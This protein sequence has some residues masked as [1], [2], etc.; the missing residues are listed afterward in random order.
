MAKENEF[1]THLV[2]LLEP[3][4]PVQAKAMFG[5]FGI[6]LKGLMFGLVADDTFY[7]KV[8]EKNRPDYEEKGLGPFTYQRGGKKFAMS[9]YRAPGEAID[10]AHDL[11]A[12]AKKAYDA[13]IRVA[14]HKKRKKP[15]KK[16]SR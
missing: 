14:G 6:Y 5:G 11:C 15:G 8:D 10:D 12:W 16:S 3:L 1:V 4:G 13:A 7:L 2:E 9:Y